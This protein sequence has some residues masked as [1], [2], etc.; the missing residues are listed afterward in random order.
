MSI[1]CMSD[2]H[3]CFDKFNKMLTEINFNENDTLYILGDIIDRGTEVLRL[4]RYIMASDNIR[5]ICGNH[6]NMMVAA[7][8]E[9]TQLAGNENPTSEETLRIQNWF[10]NGGK[11]TYEQLFEVK[12]GEEPITDLAQIFEYFAKL[13]TYKELSIDGREFILVHA[14]VGEYEESVPLSERDELDFIWDRI[15]TG[16]IPGKTIVAGHTPTVYMNGDG[17]YNIFKTKD[18]INLDGGCVFPAGQLN[19]LRLDDMKEFVVK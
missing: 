14:G 15:R 9:M 10:L 6:E 17:T 8:I 3:G 18:Y 16:R 19:C 5:L 1:Y 2:L 11:T 7:I 13:P 4:I 12:E